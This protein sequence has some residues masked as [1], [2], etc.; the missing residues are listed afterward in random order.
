VIDAGAASKREAG[1]ETESGLVPNVLSAPVLFPIDVL[2]GKGVGGVSAYSEILRQRVFGVDSDLEMVEPVVFLRPVA[3]V[4]TEQ[5][6]GGQFQIRDRLE[7][8]RESQF[9]ERALR[10]ERVNVIE[11][12]LEVVANRV[13]GSR[14]Y[15]P[16]LRLFP[17]F[18]NARKVNPT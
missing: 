15:F 3:E 1:K 18:E 12:R 2:Q 13:G 7:R 5:G 10:F 17:L 14:S 16:V 9:D 6:V 4:E 8:G 11:R